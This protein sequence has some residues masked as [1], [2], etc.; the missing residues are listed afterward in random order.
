MVEFRLFRGCV[1]L[2]YI[3]YF[4]T[5]QMVLNPVSNIFIENIFSSYYIL[6]SICLEKL[7]VVKYLK[8]VFIGMTTELCK[9][10]STN[11]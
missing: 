1:K 8:N 9:N 11:V 6:I 2:I 3:I 4:E 10:G 7:M 5:Q